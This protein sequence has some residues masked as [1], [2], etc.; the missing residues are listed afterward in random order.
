MYN[1]ANITL[2]IEALIEDDLVEILRERLLGKIT[3]DKF[4]QRY[5]INKRRRA[6][7]LQRKDQILAAVGG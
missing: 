1:D 2:E 7:M 6:R 5:D 3:H 4:M